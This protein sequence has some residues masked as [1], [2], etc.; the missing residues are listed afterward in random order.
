MQKGVQETEVAVIGAGPV[1]LLL[2][3]R[4]AQLG[5]ACII[6]EKRAQPFRHT[7]AIGIHAPSIQR[8]EQLGIVD[9]LLA[10]GVKV[11]KGAAYSGGRRL[12]ELSFERCPPPYNFVLTVPQYETERLLQDFLA[13]QGPRVLRRGANIF[14]FEPADGKIRIR[15]NAEGETVD[16]DARFVVG[17]DGRD[18]FVRKAI[19]VA[20]RGA[21]YADTFVMGDF[22][23][24]T[25]FGA[26][27][28]VFL[29]EHGLIESFPLP[30]SMRRW[31]V[32]T[33]ELKKDPEE[34]AFVHWVR[35]RAGVDLSRQLVEILT[36]F[37][38][39]HYM[40]DTFHVGPY[41]LAGDAAHVMSPIGG[42]GMNVGWFDAWSAAEALRAVL[43]EGGDADKL[44][45]AYS[46]RARL[47]ASI[48]TR[49]AEWYMALG[50]KAKLP[51]LRN[52][53][54][55][56]LLRSPWHQK[57]ANIVTMNHW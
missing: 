32:Q 44:L 52:M 39:H 36:S 51:A 22:R 42:Q 5:I 18:S 46:D 21:P 2:A 48:A 3:C 23:D 37:S 28:R 13:A 15:A 35:E 40:A 31:V 30:G 20:F 19:G 10:V 8:F 34:E 14:G 49:R 7:R 26:E 53:V 47:R 56:A 16:I 11:G 1:G 9:Q 17:C 12:G 33:E 24:T 25:D 6:L 38:V 55:R 43:R 41:L 4:L 54:L 29:D 27:A 45:D 50:R 57:F